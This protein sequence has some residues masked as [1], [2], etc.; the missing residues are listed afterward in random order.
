MNYAVQERHDLVEYP[1]QDNVRLDVYWREDR[2]GRGPAASLYVYDDE[3]LRLDCFGGDQGHC[4][5]NLKQTKGQRW[6]YPAGPAKQHIEQSAFDLMTN[7][8]FCLRTHQD[9]RIQRV[10]IDTEK[11]E[12]AASEMKRK[13]LEFSEKLGLDAGS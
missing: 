1:I 5:V 12:V 8:A 9:E 3:V 7:H 4:H 11:L 13:L 6:Y 10:K 2:G